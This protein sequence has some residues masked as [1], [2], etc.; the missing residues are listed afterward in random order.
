MGML[1]ESGVPL[2]DTV[3]LARK[4]SHNSLYQE[5]FSNIE[6]AVV[7]GRS[8]ASARERQATWYPPRRPK[9]LRLPSS[10]ASWPRC[11]GWLVPTSRRKAKTCARQAVSTLEPMIT[12]VM[13]AVVATVVLAVMLPVFDLS[14]F[15]GKG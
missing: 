15:A 12:V 3:Q 4:S 10:P 9:C 14:S 2:L 11:R 5:L 13:G 7:N 6:E 8:F 1:M